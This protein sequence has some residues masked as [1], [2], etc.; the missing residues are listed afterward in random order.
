M[1]RTCVPPNVKKSTQLQGAQRS[2]ELAFRS[3][4]I[5]VPENLIFLALQSLFL[6]LSNTANTL[7]L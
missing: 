1:R 7:L 6:V 4:D 3:T 5:R 2:P